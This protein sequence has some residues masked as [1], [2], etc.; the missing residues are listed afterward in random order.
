V[1]RKWDTARTPYERL[2]QTG[3]LTHEQ[4]QSL[5]VLYTQTNPRALRNEIYKRLA[6]IWEW[7][8]KARP[9]GQPAEQLEIETETERLA[10]IA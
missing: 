5:E 10:S 3:V 8:Q 4:Q 7:Q 2:K 1:Q 9:A 6:Q